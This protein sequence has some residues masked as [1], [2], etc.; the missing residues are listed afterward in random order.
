MRRLFIVLAKI[1]GVLEG[2]TAFLNFMQ[3]CIAFSSLFTRDASPIFPGLIL[4]I[5]YLVSSL[6][7]AWILLMRTAWLADILNLKEEGEFQGFKED[8]IFRTGVKLIGVYVTVYAIPAF[9]RA[10]LGY[11]V[12]TA[13]KAGSEF[14]IKLIPPLIQL[15]IG[16]FLTI[17]TEVVLAL[18]EKAE[19]TDGRRIWLASVGVLALVIVIGL[20]VSVLRSG[21]NDEPWFPSHKGADGNKVFIHKETNTYV[22]PSVTY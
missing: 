4:T 15:I 6:V 1:L 18:V 21:N 17:R 14:W 22:V 9:A 10:V 8:A 16:V 19:R 13:G 2:Y 3:V 12:F 7:M 11:Q 5:V 20:A